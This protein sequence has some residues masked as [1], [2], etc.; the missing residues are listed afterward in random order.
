MKVSSPSLQR[1]QVCDMAKSILLWWYARKF[2]P[3]IA[4]INK[5]R[6]AL[7]NCRRF[8]ALFLSDLLKKTFVASCLGVFFHLLSHSVSIAFSICL[9]AVFHGLSV[10]D[11]KLIL[12]AP[13]LA[14]SSASSLPSIPACALIQPIAT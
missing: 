3:V 12:S 7:H 14:S 10:S 2:C 11:H 9:M 1:R 13:I 6:S 5:E 4:L 8:L